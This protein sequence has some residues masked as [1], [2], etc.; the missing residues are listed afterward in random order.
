MA[1][2]P[3][4]LA[5]QID[6]YTKQH[7]DWQQIARERVFPC[8]AQ[9]LPAMRAA[10]QLLL[11]TVEP[12]C[13]SAQT[14]FDLDCDTLFV[15]YVG[16]G[17]GAGWVTPFCG[18]PAIL[19]GLE[20]I[21][22]CGWQDYQSIS[23][24]VAHEIGHIVHFYWRDR[25]EK[26]LGAGPWWQLYE[27][28]FA[29]RC[30]TLLRDSENWH[31]NSGINGRNWHAWCRENQA[32]LSAEF[33]KTVDANQ[34]VTPFFGSWFD[35]RGKRQT[36]YFLGHAVIVALEQTYDWKEIAL[37][38]DFEGVFRPILEE[39]AHESLNC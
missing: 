19:F 5:L 31:Q 24:L 37:L 27:E 38:D 9:R 14:L 32:W 3:D 21:A 2:W 36:G 34:P 17:S 12:I 10:H 25:C 8:L 20:N 15:I 16:I 23:G 6:D 22:E 39:M 35:V 30:E 33:L 4:L 1:A 28:G 7:V 26:S 13:A 29:Q 11:A 18:E